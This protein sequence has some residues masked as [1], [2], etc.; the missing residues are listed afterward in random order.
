MNGN[1]D[2]ETVWHGTREEYFRFY[3]YVLGSNHGTV[4]ELSAG[5][6]TYPFSYVLPPTLPSA[7]EGKFGHIRY[8]IKVTLDR[9]WKLDH[10]VKTPF[11][12]ISPID[13]NLYPQL[14][15]SVFFHRLN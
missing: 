2:S 5:V 7:F 3:Q 10:E 11:T 9:P 6:H 14:R 13:L 8:G 12:V 15:V 1:S 4:I